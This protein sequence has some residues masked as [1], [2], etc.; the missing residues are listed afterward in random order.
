[1]IFILSEYL[2]AFA[3]W[4]DAMVAKVDVESHDLCEAGD[5]LTFAGGGG[6]DD[7]LFVT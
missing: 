7:V 1:L 4:R 3:K 2:V 6:G 5:R